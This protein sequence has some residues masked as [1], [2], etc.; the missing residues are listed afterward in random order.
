MSNREL[1]AAEF[2]TLVVGGGA[3]LVFFF[4]TWQLAN[5]LEVS[6][7]LVANSLFAS[8]LC[9]VLALGLFF[10]ARMAALRVYLAV[11]SWFVWPQWF[12]VIKAMA[13][14]YATTHGFLS[15][16]YGHEYPWWG[17][18]GGLWTIEIA[19]VAVSV[20]LLWF[21]SRDRY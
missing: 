4:V 13:D 7:S 3:L 17:T 12:G 8:V 6:L 20:F 11:A 19:L 21:L 18:D 5:W 14:K 15:S 9:V 10:W 2:T 16:G 1:S